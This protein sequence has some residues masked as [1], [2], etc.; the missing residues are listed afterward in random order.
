M[1]TDHLR[2]DEGTVAG[3]AGTWQAGKAGEEGERSCKRNRAASSG[4][5]SWETYPVVSSG[6]R[7]GRRCSFL[8]PQSQP[9]S[10]GCAAAIGEEQR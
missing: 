9:A 6:S 1:L 8:A 3:R 5:G 4:C 7:P 2:N 10:L